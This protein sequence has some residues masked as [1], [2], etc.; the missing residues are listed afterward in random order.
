MNFI[1]LTMKFHECPYT[2]IC[3][4]AKGNCTNFSTLNQYYVLEKIPS[5]VR[6]LSWHVDGCLQ[7]LFFL[8]SQRAWYFILK[9]LFLTQFGASQSRA[10]LTEAKN[11]G[12]GGHKKCKL[13]MSDKGTA[14]SS[15][16]FE[17]WYSYLAVLL[18][19]LFDDT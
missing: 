2:N 17:G 6:W 7:N 12:G 10:E 3:W 1:C 9:P 15:S 16:L 14:L 18:E 8:S 13:A 19:N 4:Q 11:I 5:I